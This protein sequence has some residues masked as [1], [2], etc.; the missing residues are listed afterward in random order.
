MQTE[1]IQNYFYL[2]PR[3]I[4]AFLTSS[5]QW[6]Y[7][8]PVK[9]NSLFRQGFLSVFHTYYRGLFFFFFSTSCTGSLYK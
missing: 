1:V 4:F 5:A 7:K 3:N 8:G 2:I 6:P 9:V